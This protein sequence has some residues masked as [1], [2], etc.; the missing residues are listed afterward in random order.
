MAN[1]HQNCSDF[2]TSTGFAPLPA[3]CAT[4]AAW[5]EADRRG[6]PSYRA[7]AF[8]QGFIHARQGRR[9]E[10]DMPNTNDDYRVGFFAA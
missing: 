8:T 4:V 2:S 1:S 7:N 3:D 6:L 9:V 10:I 5:A